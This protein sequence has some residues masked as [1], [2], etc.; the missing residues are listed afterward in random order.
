RRV[1]KAV[2]ARVIAGVENHHNFCIPA[3]ER[4]PTPDGPRSIAVLQAGDE[5]YSF[6][7][8][9]GLVRAKVKDAWSSGRK[10]IYTIRTAHRKIR[11]TAGHPILTLNDGPRWVE[12][13]NIR[14]GDQVVCAEGYFRRDRPLPPGHARFIGAFLGD[15]WVRA[16]TSRRGYSFGLAVGCA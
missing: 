7:P 8:Q 10:A 3:T 16:E 2:G 6:D 9:R 11:V 13:E 14:P 5:L 12:A 1:T 4:V 15:G